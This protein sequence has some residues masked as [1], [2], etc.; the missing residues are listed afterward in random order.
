ML[1]DAGVDECSWARQNRSKVRY[2]E[3]GLSNTMVIYY[4]E[5]KLVKY[6]Y[7]G[8]CHNALGQVIR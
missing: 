7:T 4:K 8:R 6:Q 2:I 3:K 5:E 1:T